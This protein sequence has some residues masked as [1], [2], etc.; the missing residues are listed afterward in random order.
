MNWFLAKL[1]FEIKQEAAGLPSEFD[2]QLRLLQAANAREALLKTCALGKTQA[3][4]FLNA[5]GEKVEWRF[6]GVAD[7]ITLGEL[8]DGQEV[9]SLSPEAEESEAYLDYIELKYRQLQ[10]QLSSEPTVNF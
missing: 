3:Q 5:Y 9:Y 8:S 4:E 6:L 7:L 2:E 1:S 10:K